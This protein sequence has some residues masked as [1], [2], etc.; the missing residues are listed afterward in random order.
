MIV[1]RWR[2][3][4]YLTAPSSRAVCADG[5]SEGDVL[6]VVVV[7]ASGDL[8]K[9][10]TYPA[11]FELYLAGL[12]PTNILICGYAR[13]RIADADFRVCFCRFIAIVLCWR[14]CAWLRDA[15]DVGPLDS[16]LCSSDV[17][18]S[19]AASAVATGRDPLLYHCDVILYDVTVVV[20]LSACLHV[21][22]ADRARCGDASQ[23]HLRPYLTVGTDA[24]KSG[25]LD[26]C[27]YRAGAYDSAS[28][29]KVVCDELAPREA[30]MSSSGTVNRLFYLAVPPTVFLP[31]SASINASGFSS[32]GWTRVVVEKPFGRDAESSLELSRGLALYLKEEQVMSRCTCCVCAHVTVVVNASLCLCMRYCGACVCV[33]VV[34]LCVRASASVQIYRI[35]H[36]LGKEMVQNLLIQRFANVIFEPLWNRQHISNVQVR[37]CVCVC[38]LWL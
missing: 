7:G 33:T 1:L 18:C 20:P 12:L 5:V 32:R 13:S 8:A 6:T 37:V 25:F 3:M 14:G 17:P 9:K 19:S 35:D 28:D 21:A 38:L 11:L 36:Y 26:L 22:C 27:F 4:T 10:K 31:M 29:L 24:E 34:L 16:S 30:S 23:S 15:W 2:A